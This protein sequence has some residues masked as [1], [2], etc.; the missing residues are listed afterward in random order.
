[1]RRVVFVAIAIVSAAVLAGGAQ[2]LDPAGL[3]KPG[4]DSWP[5]YNG[6]YSGRRFSTSSSSVRLSIRTS[7]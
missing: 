7:D 3:V 6:D 5:M 4:T 2:G 1:M